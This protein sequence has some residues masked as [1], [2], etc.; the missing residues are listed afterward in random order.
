MKID[1]SILNDIND[2]FG[3][4]YLYENLINHKKYVGQT[5]KSILER[6]RNHKYQ[7]YNSYFHNA[8]TKYGENNFQLTVIDYAFSADELN[9]KNTGLDF[10]TQ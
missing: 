2:Y 8:L 1:N 5:T 7:K 9:K 10:I 4:I 6:H 3:V